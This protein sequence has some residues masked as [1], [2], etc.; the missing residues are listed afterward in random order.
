[1]ARATPARLMGLRIS[2]R[3]RCHGSTG[4]CG[5]FSVSMLDLGRFGVFVR[6]GL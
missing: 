5:V 4:D 1:M 2:M 6:F 3:E